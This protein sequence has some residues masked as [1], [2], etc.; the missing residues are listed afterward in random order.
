[1]CY[2]Y[3]LLCRA[4]RWLLALVLAVTPWE[5]RS[6]IPKAVSAEQTPTLKNIDMASDISHWPSF[7][8][9]LGQLLLDYLRAGLLDLA[10]F[11]VSFPSGEDFSS[12]T[13]PS[14]FRA[15]SSLRRHTSLSSISF[16]Q[17]L[18]R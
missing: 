14:R 15:P 4:C 8:R 7:E 13:G 3:S 12:G 5:E 6:N 2:G 11:D 18:R 1:M 17:G 10:G 16:R 9:W